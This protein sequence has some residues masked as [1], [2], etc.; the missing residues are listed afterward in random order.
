MGMDV[1]LEHSVVN[2]AP[3][4]Y[5]RLLSDYYIK[6][7]SLVVVVTTIKLVV[8]AMSLSNEG[9]EYWP[10]LVCRAS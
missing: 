8:D 1:F 4:D 9:R 3:A 10:T 2:C 5:Y 7:P 6:L